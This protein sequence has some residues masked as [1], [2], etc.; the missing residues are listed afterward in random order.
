MDK[1]KVI[2][3]LLSKQKKFNISLELERIKKILKLLDNPQEK[4]KIIHIAGTNGKGSTS[5]IINQILIDNGYN[6][7]LY[8][9]PHLITY[10]ER[11]KINNIPISDADFLK[12]L[13]KIIDLSTQNNI[14]ITE[15][16]LLTAV[17]Y[18]YFY[19]KKVDF[20]IVEVGL[21]GR[22]DAT[23]CIENPLISVITSISHDHTDRLGN[24]YKKIAFE[25]AGIIKK[26]SPVIFSKDNKAYKYLLEYANDISAKVI[27]PIKTKI[28]VLNNKNY[29]TIK[30]EKFEFSLK[31][32]HQSQNASLAYSTIKY[33]SDNGIKINNI[34]NSFNKIKWSCRFECFAN[35]VILDG[36]HNPDGA[37]ILK[38]CLNDY[39][40]NHKK[41]FIFTCL[42]NKDYK[43][44]QSNL[45]NENDE[46]Y[47]FDMKDE[48]FISKEN[49]ENCKGV[50]DIKT[51]KEMIKRKKQKDL[52]IICGSLYALGYILGKIKICS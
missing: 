9:S 11:I 20:A 13:K 21:G 49:I 31:G 44:I 2:K 27:S 23:N 51:L 25:K 16:E 1:Y 24:S 5:A 26:N 47:F 6:V 39:F 42:K 4:L 12:I 38:M 40:P 52:L 36:C 35:N 45:F 41:K 3:T 7:G 32:K 43:K 28:S 50:L 29:L 37:K 10:N 22:Y 34:N 15:F 30:N 14:D 17:M 46:I 48:K 19:Q 18:E 33:L 8:T